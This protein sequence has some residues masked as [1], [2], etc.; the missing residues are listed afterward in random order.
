M[1]TSETATAATT[2][3]TMAAKNAEPAPAEATRTPPT[4]G[5]TIRQPSGSTSWPSAFACT[6][7]RS[8]TRSGTIAP[9]A[10]PAN[11]SPA[12][13]SVTITTTCQSSSTSDTASVARPSMATARRRSPAAITSRLSNRSAATPPPSSSTTIGTL[14]A[15]PTIDSAVGTFEIS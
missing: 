5:P 9:D 11:A 12:P 7:I 13:K 3:A 8:G 6:S 4:A 14:H 15:T 1:R 2:N 10:G